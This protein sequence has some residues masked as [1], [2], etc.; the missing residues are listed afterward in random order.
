MNNDLQDR[1]DAELAF[2]KKICDELVKTMNECMART[3][4]INAKLDKIIEKQN[5][6][7]REANHND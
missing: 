7:N 6:E 1:L 3:D 2:T 4:S 5:K